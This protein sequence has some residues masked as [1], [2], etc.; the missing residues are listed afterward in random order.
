MKT[1][2]TNVND[3]RGKCIK[4]VSFVDQSEYI[5]MGLIFDDNSYGVFTVRNQGVN[6]TCLVL[7]EDKDINEYD[8]CE[9]KIISENEYEEYTNSLEE[10]RKKQQIAEAPRLREKRRQ[11]YLELKKEFGE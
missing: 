2:I 9:L 11:R 8:E 10:E 7:Y 6:E 4:S 5:H 1:R 3:M